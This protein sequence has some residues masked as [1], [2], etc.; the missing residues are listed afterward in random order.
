MGARRLPGLDVRFDSK[1]RSPS[2][3]EVSSGLLSVPT[4]LTQAL[5]LN[6]RPNYGGGADTVLWYTPEQLFL[7]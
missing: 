4:A 1:P 5:V 6:N 2:M 7:G 3:T